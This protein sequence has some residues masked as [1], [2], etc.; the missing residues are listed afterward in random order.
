MV[1]NRTE[2]TS[3]KSLG[4]ILPGAKGRGERS[5]RITRIKKKARARAGRMRAEGGVCQR[6]RSTL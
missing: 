3:E 6:R 4:C 2:A 1:A 5:E